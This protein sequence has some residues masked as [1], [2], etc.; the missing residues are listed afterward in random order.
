[1]SARIAGEGLTITEA[2]N[3][4]FLNEWWNPSNNNQAKDRVIRIGQERNVN[5][6]TFYAKGTIEERLKKILETKT[7]LYE[8]LIDGLVDN[9]ALGK[10]L[11]QN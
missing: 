11:L 4:I 9:E 1:L 3:V 8:N 6:T 7:E 10:T 5:I 2:N